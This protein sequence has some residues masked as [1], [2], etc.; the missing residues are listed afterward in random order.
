MRTSQT[1]CH[2]RVKIRAMSQR[3]VSSMSRHVTPAIE[4]TCCASSDHATVPSRTPQRLPERECP[5]SAVREAASRLQRALNRP[6]RSPAP[7]TKGFALDRAWAEF[8]AR[9]EQLPPIPSRGDELSGRNL[10]EGL[11]VQA[12]SDK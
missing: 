3:K 7:K 1:V 12:M 8:L 10:A 6:C 11:P 2:E 4:S 9:G 5:C